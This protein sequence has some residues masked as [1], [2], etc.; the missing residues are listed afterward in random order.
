MKL[1]L[2]VLSGILILSLGFESKRGSAR[3]VPVAFQDTPKYQYFVRIPYQIIQ[4]SL[5]SLI[6]YVIPEIGKTKTV[7]DANF[8]KAFSQRQFNRIS[9]FASLDSVLITKPKK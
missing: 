9:Q 4:P 3:A 8:I 5:D 2:L 6:K 1:S 7:D